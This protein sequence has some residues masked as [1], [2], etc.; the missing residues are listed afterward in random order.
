MDFSK[1][2]GLGESLRSDLSSREL[3]CGK[4]CPILSDAFGY[5]YVRELCRT[6]YGIP[7]TRCVRAE[8]LDVAGADVPAILAAAER[9][10]DA[11]AAELSGR[12]GGPEFL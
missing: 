2:V 7:D 3:C 12:P 8:G 10:I 1:P 11:L 4:G 6:F 9:E 5:G